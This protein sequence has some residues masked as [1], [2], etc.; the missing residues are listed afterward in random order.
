[1]ESFGDHRIAMSFAVAGTVADG[2]VTVRDVASVETSFPGFEAC[3]GAVGAHIRCL[4]E[5]PA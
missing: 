3:L 5:A 4:D 1:V 2:P